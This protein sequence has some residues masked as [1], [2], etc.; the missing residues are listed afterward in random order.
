MKDKR[1]LYPSNKV[2]CWSSKIVTFGEER[3]RE[4]ERERDRDDCGEVLR[5]GVSRD[6]T[7]KSFT[8]SSSLLKE[9]R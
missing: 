3:E 5:L 8:S 2:S 9:E 4:R 1:D 7:N 6:V